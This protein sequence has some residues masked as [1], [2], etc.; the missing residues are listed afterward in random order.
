MAMGRRRAGR[1]SRPAADSRIERVGGF[2]QLHGF[3][4]VGPESVAPA[5]WR[6]YDPERRALVRCY[7]LDLTPAAS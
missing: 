3:R 7:R 6:G 2:F 4:A 1:R 5:K